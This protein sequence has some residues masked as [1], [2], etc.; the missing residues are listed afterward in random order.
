[1]GERYDA[2]RELGAWRP[3]SRRGWRRHDRA[4]RRRPARAR[5]LAAD[6]RDRGAAAGRHH[7]ARAGR[8]RLRPRPEHGRL[9]PPRGARASAAREVRLRFA[10]MLEPDGSLYVENLRAR[11]AAGHVRAPRRR[12]RGLRAALH[13][14]RLPLRRGHRPRPA[15][16]ARRRSP[17]ASCTPTRRAA[18]GSSART[19]WS[20]SS[21]ATSTGA[22]AATS[23]PSRPTARSATSGSAGSPTPR[24]SSPPRRS[25]WTSPPSSPSG[26]TTCSTRS[27][28]RARTPDVA[29]RLVLE[30]DGAPAWAD[31]G[32]IVPWI[33][34]RRYGD[35]RLVERHWDA[36]ERYMAYLQ[37]HNPDLLWTSRR[38]NDYGD[39]LVG[40]RGHAARRPRDRLLGLRR[41]AHGRDGA[42]RSA[43][44]TAPSTTSGCAPGSPP[45]STASTSATTPSSRA[46]RRPSTCSRCTWTCCPRRCASAPPSGSSRTSSATTV[47]LTTGFVGV[48]LLCP[49]LSETGY[50]DVAHRLL[51][52]ETFPSWGYSI[53]HGAT[54]IWER[55]DGWTDT[56]GFQTP[57]ELVQP[58]LAR[59]GRPVALRV[60]RRASGR[61]R[62]ATS[63][64]LIA[65]EPGELEWAR[66][67]YR[68]VRGP[69]TSAWRRE[70]DELQ[71]EVEIPPNVTGD[72]RRP[73][74]RDRRGG[75]GRHAFTA[76]AS[77]VG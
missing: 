72:R 12:R 31:A 64:S 70:G 42:A 2:R 16:R 24:S 7:R 69:I 38:G 53:R 22:S 47:H 62:P 39:W 3:G 55:W 11:A 74:R 10:E 56:D 4:A 13:V 57:D 9:G 51:R 21:G 18:A 63:A 1:M 65:P 36:M 77:P 58:L 44:A 8:A 23:S 30:R 60:R 41:Q 6:A 67:V 28:P 25:T 14:P 66:V 40:R 59:L 46:T 71:L 48:G 35:L 68:S 15:S 17:A 34:W 52:N 49:V 61:R 29:P 45:R 73:R 37:R 20:T 32:V 27:R 54:T 5:A 76:A 26:A 50:S 75:P 19:S 43:A 33:A